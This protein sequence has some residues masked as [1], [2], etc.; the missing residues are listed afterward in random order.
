MNKLLM[1]FFL[2]VLSMHGKAQIP[3]GYTLVA[4]PVQFK[5]S[6]TQAAGKTNSIKSD[7]VQEKTMT[8]L[9]EKI[10]SNGKFFYKKDNKVRM[11]YIAPFKYL[12]IINGTKLSIKDGAKESTIS[13]SGSKV[14]RQVSQIM[15][16]CV[17]GNMLA[18]PDFKTNVY[19]GKAG[20]LIEMTPVSKGLMEFFSKIFVYI[21]SSD[22]SVSKVRMVE[23]SGD[24]TILNFTHKETNIELSDSLF[25][26]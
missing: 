18:N 17:S 11:E 23:V 3:E 19:K 14:F 2:C 15:L 26:L 8:M 16:D 10:I 12:M 13:T 7:F 1:F 9:S 20:Y 6:F 21:D 24:F 4:D 22:Q 25:T 5:S